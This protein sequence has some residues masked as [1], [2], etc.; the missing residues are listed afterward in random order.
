M[1]RDRDDAANPGGSGGARAKQSNKQAHGNTR[2]AQ[3]QRLLEAL[4][5][6]PVN[7]FEGRALL[8]VPHVAGRIQDLREAGFEI[9]TTWTLARGDTGNLHRIARYALLAEPLRQEVR[10]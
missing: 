4:R 8:G 2:A 7:T 10:P 1:T 5:A 6:A 9:V 3:Q